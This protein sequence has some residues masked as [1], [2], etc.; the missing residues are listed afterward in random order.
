M[1]AP[2]DKLTAAL[3]A[4]PAVQEAPWK[5]TADFDGQ[6]GEVLTRGYAQEMD[7]DNP[8]AM[9]QL[10]TDAGLDPSKVMAVGPVRV[11][12]WD[13]P[14]HGKQW[15]YR[16]RLVARL[17]PGF[18]VDT[19]LAGIRPG[20]PQQ[21]TADAGGHWYTL[22]VGDIHLGKSAEA[23]GGTERILARY[24]QTLDNA[25]AELKLLR[26]L[27]IAGV[28]VA[29]LGDLIEG[30]VSQGGR[31]IPMM[32][33]T[34]TQQITAATRL[35]VQTVRTFADLGL[36]VKVSAVGGNHGDTQ[37][38][39]GQPLGDN[40]DI[41]IVVAAKDMLDM[42]PQYAD[43]VEWVIPPEDQSYMTFPVGD[44]IFVAVH[45]HQFRGATAFQKVEKWWSGQALS[46]MPAGAA[47]VLMAGH[48]HTFSHQT[49]SRNKTAIFSP[50]MEVMSRWFHERT[51]ATSQRGAACYLTRGGVVSRVSIV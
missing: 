12:T 46:T 51:G 42:L 1:T 43:G 37:R 48:F 34:L 13:V 21:S 49:I 35:A 23:G 6:T 10:L 33:L 18:D 2:A 36:P 40:H 29:F 44:T 31:N 17:R 14:G 5:P 4:V 27:G 16:F 15:S 19:V 8:D 11:S 25:V 22:Q 30:V 32:D 9:D 20:D 3:T 45:G 47:H 41:G 50:S 7:P 28:H 26:S 38:T 39:A 24:Q